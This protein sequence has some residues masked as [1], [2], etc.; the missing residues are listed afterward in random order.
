MPKKRL[1]WWLSALLAVLLFALTGCRAVQG[2]DVAQAIQNGASVTSGASNT[3]IQLELIPGTGT[4]SVDNKALM[5][6]FN[7]LKLEINHAIV[8]DN[9]HFSA[10]GV[11]TYSKG[12]IPFKLNFLANKFVIQ[13]EG[14]PK[15]IVYDPLSGQG[16]TSTQAAAVLSEDVQSKL[17][18]KMKEVS[19]AFVKLLLGKFPNPQHFTVS[20]VTDTINHETLNL[21]KAHIELN[22]TELASLLKSMVSGL[23]EDKQGVQDFIGQMYDAL[24]PVLQQQAAQSSEINT[25]LEN[26][27]LAVGIA[28]AYVQSF[29]E[30]AGEE[31]DK[32]SKDSSTTFFS[33][34]TT[35][36][37]DLFIDSDKQLR[38][39]SIELYVPVAEPDAAV[40]AFKLNFTT[41]AWD[42]N[43]PLKVDLIDLSGGSMN[44]TSEPNNFFVFYNQLDKQ[45]AFYKLLKDDLHV[46]RKVIHLAM[47]ESG[48]TDEY[49]MQPY[50]N[51]DNVTMVPVRFISEQLGAEVK[52]NGD[53]KQVTI[54][55]AL[56]GKTIVLTLDNKTATVNGTSVQLESAAALHNSSTFVPVRFIAET[57]GSKVEFD[58][59]TR[60]V[61]IKRD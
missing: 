29:L 3:S 39:E 55:D 6:T 60:V 53:L 4:L 24:L 47:N 13:I 30:K 33:D 44:M 18:S 48:D 40:T 37:I 34:K 46:T 38:K 8:Q 27:P 36:N 58:D 35:F 43:K 12:S 32:V 2:L 9:Q 26:K 41:E 59:A 49:A 51:A 56:T 11:L 31:L 23:L 50:I 45:S 28:Y 7:P 22:G 42:L 5:D 25:M 10:D 61:T 14:A 57:L 19:P 21:Q 17:T 52:W 15:P 16:G 54:I 20:S 1:S